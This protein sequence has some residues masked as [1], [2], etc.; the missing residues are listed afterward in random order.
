MSFRALFHALPLLAAGAF[1]APALA[2]G[3]TVYLISPE[4]GAVLSSP[5]TVRFGLAGWGVAPAGV[6]M[7]GTAHHH[8]L[9][10]RPPFGEGEDD[11]DMMQG[12]LYADAEH[13][14]FGGG[15]TETV[16]DL[17]P[18]RHS[19]QL[20]LGDANHVPH[21]PPIVSEVIEITVE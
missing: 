7:P 6:D 12:G 10:N 9:L 1:A 3:P 2:E 16:L 13:L 8:L 4:D 14:H 5:V 11:A 18:G 19:L 17:P 15:Q 21:D 20:V